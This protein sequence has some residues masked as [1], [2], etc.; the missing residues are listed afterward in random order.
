[1]IANSDKPVPFFS[2]SVVTRSACSHFFGACFVFFAA[3]VV[4][5]GQRPAASKMRLSLSYVPDLQAQIRSRTPL[6]V[7]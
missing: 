3:R 2:V 4:I 5:L 1:M 6:R 7:D